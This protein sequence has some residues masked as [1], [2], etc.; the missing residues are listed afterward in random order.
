MRAVATAC[1]AM[2]RCKPALFLSGR[3]ALSQA[4]TPEAQ[5]TLKQSWLKVDGVSN[6][7]TLECGVLSISEDTVSGGSASVLALKCSHDT[8]QQWLELA[9]ALREQQ[10][11]AVAAYDAGGSPEAPIWNTPRAIVAPHF[12]GY[13][14]TSP[15]PSNSRPQSMDDHVRLLKSAAAAAHAGREIEGLDCQQYIALL[16]DLGVSTKRLE[17]HFF[18]GHT[19]STSLTGSVIDERSA[20]GVST[21]RLVQLSERKVVPAVTASAPPR[22]RLLGQAMG[23]G[24]AVHAAASDAQFAASL[25]AIVLLEPHAFSLLADPR[26]DHDALDEWRTFAGNLLA[27][28]HAGEWDAW[29]RAYA[30]FWLPAHAALD[31]ASKAQ[32]LAGAELTMHELSAN[33][34]ATNTAVH[35][36]D[37]RAADALGALRSCSKSI[38]VP[39]ALGAGAARVL[40]ALAHLLEKHAGFDRHTLPAPALPASDDGAAMQAL[41]RCLLDMA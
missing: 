36:A 20:L 5:W 34:E 30:K 7:L 3:R 12:Y 9:S 13:G 23:G 14:N 38:V 21:E 17:T 26:A 39:S 1:I 31:E 6:P 16:K 8:H 22:W 15:W 40:A 33:L 29:A 28:G 4:A 32:L 24:I 2:R 35:M 18:E 10:A 41:A 19:T 25:D 27:L 37:T 11:Q